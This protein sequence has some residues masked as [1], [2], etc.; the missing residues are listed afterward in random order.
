M[1]EQVWR[2]GHAT[3]LLRRFLNIDCHSR[4]N[5]L[6]KTGKAEDIFRMFNREYT[7][8]GNEFLNH[9][10]TLINYIFSNRLIPDVIKTGLLSNADFASSSTK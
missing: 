10:F 8:S 2:S 6:L 1:V 5:Q 3:H 7:V 4:I 9:L